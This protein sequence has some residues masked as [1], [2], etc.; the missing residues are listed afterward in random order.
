MVFP[1]AIGVKVGRRMLAE[2]V[3]SRILLFDEMMSSPEEFEEI[4]WVPVVVPSNVKG[5]FVGIF[6]VDVVK[7]ILEGELKIKFEPEF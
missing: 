1:K 3:Q 6:T 2:V 4:F 5:T 7:E